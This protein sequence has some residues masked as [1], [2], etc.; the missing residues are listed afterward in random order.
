MHT[1]ETFRARFPEFR[2]VADATLQ[3]A[4]DAAESQTSAELFGSLED[5][6]HGQMTAHI[7]ASSPSGR[8][9]R[10]SKKSD[11]TTYGKERIRLEK[12]K[13]AAHG[14]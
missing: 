3:A 5:E 10:L 7:L 4:L 9:A 6:A 11:E 14:L 1:V 13:G 8:E 12:I 2:A